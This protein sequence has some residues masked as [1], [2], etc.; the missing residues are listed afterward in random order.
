MKRYVFFVR[1]LIYYLCFSFNLENGKC[2]KVSVKTSNVMFGGT[3]SKVIMSLFG[4][5]GE[6]GKKYLRF[7]LYFT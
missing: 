6:T 3:D 7:E 2:Y 5:K 4:E 1:D